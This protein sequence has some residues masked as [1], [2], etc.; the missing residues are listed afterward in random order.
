MEGTELQGKRRRGREMQWGQGRGSGR[1]ENGQRYEKI[2][3]IHNT[4]TQDHVCDHCVHAGVRKLHK[5]V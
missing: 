1:K 2:K 4:K 5:P 3:N